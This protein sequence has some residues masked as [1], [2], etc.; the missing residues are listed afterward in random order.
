MLPAW[1]DKDPLFLFQE[2]SAEPQSP[3]PHDGLDA[4]STRQEQ[5]CIRI[6]LPSAQQTLRSHVA[7]RS[8]R[9]SRDVPVL[10]RTSPTK[11]QFRRSC[12]PYRR[13]SPLQDSL[14]S[15]YS[16]TVVKARAP[17]RAVWNSTQIY[18]LRKSLD[19][20]TAAILRRTPGDWLSC[21]HAICLLP[22]DISHDDLVDAISLFRSFSPL[23]FRRS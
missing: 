2:D 20:L 17:P 10:R 3:I 19:L 16:S 6:R 22:A 12:F 9:R 21:E 8:S 23:H 13:K 11:Q 4:P 18:H 14:P 5:E 7:A 1:K 15:Q